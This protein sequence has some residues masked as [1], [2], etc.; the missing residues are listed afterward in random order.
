[1]H[2][3]WARR[4]ARRAIVSTTVT[5]KL[6]A[7]VLTGKRLFYDAKDN[8]L[9]L[10]EYLS[11]ATCHH[12]GAQDGRVWDFTGY[13]EGLRNTISLRGHG[14]TRQGPLHWSGNFDEVQDFENQIRNF[15]GGTG[16]ISGGTPHP[17]LGSLNAE[18]S[19]DLDAL[20]AYVTSLTS[21][22]PSPIAGRASRATWA[23]TA[24]V[25]ANTSPAR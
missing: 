1:M 4:Q 15:A 25:Q 9:A 16:L 23:T 6:S 11:C 18:R 3:S 12:D 2:G 8:R 20:A 13:G 24:V 22:T 19:P 14:G 17:P 7:Q 21:A 10:Q 5:E